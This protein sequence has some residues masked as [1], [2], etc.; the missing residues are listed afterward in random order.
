MWRTRDLTDLT[1]FV[2]AW[3]SDATLERCLLSVLRSGRDVKTVVIDQSSVD[4]TVDIARRLGADVVSHSVGLGYARQLAFDA[5]RTK[6]LAFV[7]SDE[8]IIQ[9]R[10]F[11]IAIGV[12]ENP[13]VG[14]VVGMSVGHRFA[15]GLPMGLLV[16]RAKDF[17]G[18]IIPSSVNAREEFYVRMR[19]RSMGLSVVFVP[20]A[21]IHRSQYRKYKPE[22]E[23]ANTRIVAGFDISQLAFTAK[24]VLLQS[25]NSRS[26]KNIA[27]APLFYLKF[28]RGFVQPQKWRILKQ[29]K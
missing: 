13:R 4:G 8:E 16:L 5:C 19:L 22:W 11:E 7:D 9:H 23:G 15:Y 2:C 3:N 20:G 27:Y 21:M 29:V 10:F 18:R 14:A 24:V 26:P 1:V 17:Q 6:Y 25:L 28:L 12:L